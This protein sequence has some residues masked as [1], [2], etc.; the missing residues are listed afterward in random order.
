[1]F[2]HEGLGVW[3]NPATW[4][5]SSTDNADPSDDPNNYP[6]PEIGP[7]TPATNAVTKVPTSPVSASSVSQTASAGKTVNVMNWIIG[8]GVVVMTALAIKINWPR[9]KSMMRR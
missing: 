9:I 5:S 3:Y 2:E 8:G 4:G 7:V 6:E 1:M